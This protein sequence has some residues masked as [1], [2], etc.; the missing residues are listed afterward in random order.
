MPV[1]LQFQA[2]HAR[3]IVSLLEVEIEVQDPTDVEEISNLLNSQQFTRMVTI[4]NDIN[5][6]QWSFRPAYGSSTSGRTVELVRR[7]DREEPQ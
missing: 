2:L 4:D 6:E 5:N 3:Q 7:P 1:R